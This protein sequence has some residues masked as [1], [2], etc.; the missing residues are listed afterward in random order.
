MNALLA[1]GK[2][3]PLEED[4]VE[5]QLGRNDTIGMVKQGFVEIALSVDNHENNPR[6]EKSPKSSLASRHWYPLNMAPAQ[7][8]FAIHLGPS[9]SGLPSPPPHLLWACPS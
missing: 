2:R 7:R 1:Q 3:L 4:V 5:D 8:T 9:R 6:L